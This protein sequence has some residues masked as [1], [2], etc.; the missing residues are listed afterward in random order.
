MTIESGPFELGDVSGDGPAVLCVHGL[1]GTPYEV[2][3]IAEALA[4]NGFVCV[5]PLL[6]GH[7]TTPAELSIVSHQQ[8]LEAVERAWDALAKRHPRVYVLG[9][10][11]GGLLSL[12]LA[13]NRPV[14]GAVIMA[15][16][17]RLGRAVRYGVPLLHRWLREIPKTPGILD[18]QARAVH[19]GYDRMPLSSVNQLIHLARRVRGDLAR[20]DAPLQLIFSRC[21]ETVD[22]QNLDQIINGVKSPQIETL[23]LEDSGHVLPVDRESVKVAAS[24]VEFLTSQEASTLDA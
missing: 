24:V 5:G 3:P 9:L 2:R 17:L 4:H 15:A 16:P 19:P 21:D 8:W 7:G 18:P 11:L 22:L 23:I 1:T 12:A 14:A 13:Q 6:P 20:I 10:S